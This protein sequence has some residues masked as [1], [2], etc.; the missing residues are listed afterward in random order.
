MGSSLRRALV[1]FFLKKNNDNA[2]LKGEWVEMDTFSIFTTPAKQKDLMINKIDDSL[3]IELR[4][5]R[6]K[7]KMIRNIVT[8]K[9][10]I[11]RKH[12]SMFFNKLRKTLATEN[13]LQFK[14]DPIEKTRS[15]E[16]QSNYDGEDTVSETPSVNFLD[17]K[18]DNDRLLGISS[19]LF[20]CRVCSGFSPE[21]FLLSCGHLCC[22]DHLEENN[23]VIKSS[24]PS[25]PISL[26]SSSGSL[27]GEKSNTKYHDN[28]FFL[29]TDSLSL[30]INQ[31]MRAQ[32]PCSSS[33]ITSPESSFINEENPIY[34]LSESSSFMQ[35]ETRKA[36]PHSQTPYFCRQCGI[37]VDMERNSDKNKA[38][39]MEEANKIFGLLFLAHKKLRSCK[40][41]VVTEG[42]T[43]EWACKY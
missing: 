36:I 7:K 25:S 1:E 33:R 42:D 35:S 9:T 17:G 24:C 8:S 5:K 34:R 14:D 6:K 23:K 41:C 29:S 38:F 30:I 18:N 28:N 37:P 19:I 12:R 4:P 22:M 21:C 16:T 39:P 2:D 20:S 3:G 32:P 26:Y 43:V 13:P 27:G 11:N 31:L 15:M 10:R 40:D